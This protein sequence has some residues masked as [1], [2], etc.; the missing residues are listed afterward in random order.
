MV[1]R[2]WPNRGWLKLLVFKAIL[3]CIGYRFHPWRYSKLLMPFLREIVVNS[4][5]FAQCEQLCH[6]KQG[7]P[8]SSWRYIRIIW[9]ISNLTQC[10]GVSK[11]A[12]DLQWLQKFLDLQQLCRQLCI[13]SA[14]SKIQ[15]SGGSPWFLKHSSQLPFQLSWNLTSIWM[16]IVLPWVLHYTFQAWTDVLDTPGHFKWHWMPGFTQLNQIL[17]EVFM[18][19]HHFSY[20]PGLSLFSTQ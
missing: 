13:G 3:S 4:R 20:L 6:R 16:C 11:Q 15:V 5:T 8:M 2:E 19:P 18:L 14:R 17:S 1:G 10:P 9:G 12:T 7:K